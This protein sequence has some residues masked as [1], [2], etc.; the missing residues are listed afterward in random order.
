MDVPLTVNY[1]LDGNA[2][3]AGGG[4]EGA[5]SY[6]VGVKLTYA[7]LYEFGLRYA[8]TDAQTKTLNNGTVS[9]NGNVGGTDRGW[10]TFT[11]KT[12]F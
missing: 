6:S 7:Q 2:A 11:F 1:G 4:S 8:D 12:S 3:S 5:L 9:G 10:L